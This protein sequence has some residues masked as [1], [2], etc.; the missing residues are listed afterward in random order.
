MLVKVDGDETPAIQ[1]VLSAD[2]EREELMK[3]EK[4]LLAEIAVTKAGKTEVI[5]GQEKLPEIKSRDKKLEKEQ[6]TKSLDARL[7]AVYSRLQAIEA[8]KAEP[9]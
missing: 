1:S 5:V 3:E 7:S 6:E 2:V 4:E 9:R 8:D